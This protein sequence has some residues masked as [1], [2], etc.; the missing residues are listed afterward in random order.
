MTIHEHSRLLAGFF[1]IKGALTAVGWVLSGAFFGG[2]WLMAIFAA[3]FM[4]TGW[5]LQNGSSDARILGIVASVL[6]LGSFPL[7]TA[8]GVYGLWFFLMRSDD[9][10]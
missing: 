2:H 6:C 1:F 3:F 7:G 4:L 10:F 5:K 8:L 9:E